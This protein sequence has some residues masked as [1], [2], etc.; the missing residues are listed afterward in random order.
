MSRCEVVG[1]LLEN[2]R[3]G[4]EH[5]EEDCEGKCDVEVEDEY[6]RFLEVECYRLDEEAADDG[7]E[8]DFGFLEFV[9]CDELGVFESWSKSLGSLMEDCCW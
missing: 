4:F 6:D 9:V 7:E 2:V 1:V 3:E 5:S 8:G